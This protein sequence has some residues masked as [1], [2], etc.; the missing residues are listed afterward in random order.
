MVDIAGKTVTA[1]IGEA[2]RWHSWFV[3]YG[4]YHTKNPEERVVVV[5]MVEA[6]NDWEWWAPKAVN[7]IFQRI[8]A[9]QSYRD[10]VETL[11]LDR[12]ER[13]HIDSEEVPGTG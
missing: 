6:V 13:Y 8:F 11:K 5:V 4:P 7:V 1:E 2:D 3:G 9:G 10:A 12:D